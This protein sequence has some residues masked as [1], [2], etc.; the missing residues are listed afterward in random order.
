MVVLK[1]SSWL[2]N[3]KLSE[4]SFEAPS[5]YPRSRCPHL[6]VSPWAGAAACCLC[7]LI[8]DY[9]STFVRICPLPRSLTTRTINTAHHTIHLHP[10]RHFRKQGYLYS[11]SVKTGNIILDFTKWQNTQYFF[12]QYGLLKKLFRSPPKPKKTWTRGTLRSQS[13]LPDYFYIHIHDQQHSTQQPQHPSRH[14]MQ[15]SIRK[16]STYI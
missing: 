2:Y 10:C 15:H 8:I 13:L 9:L 14:T 11:S 1:P 5:E 7:P 6:S 3:F 16:I 4:G 12:R